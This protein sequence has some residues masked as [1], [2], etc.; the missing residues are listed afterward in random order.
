MRPVTL[1]S[2]VEG[3][4]ET[5]AL[6]VLLRRMAAEIAPEVYVQVT[7]HGHDARLKVTPL[8]ATWQ[9]AAIAAAETAWA[10]SWHP[11]RSGCRSTWPRGSLRQDR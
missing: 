11:P 10:G 5:T 4:G 6:P 9:M 8:N 7:P 2:V 1:A 3:H